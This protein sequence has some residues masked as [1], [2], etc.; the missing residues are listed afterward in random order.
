MDYRS[1]CRLYQAYVCFQVL[2]FHACRLIDNDPALV[3][4]S[5]MESFDTRSDV[6]SVQDCAAL[7]VATVPAVMSHFRAAMRA[8]RPEEL[9]LPQFRTLIRLRWHP[10]V[11]ISDIAEHLG[12]AL[13]TTSQLVDGLVKRGYVTRESAVGDRR[14]MVVTLT[15]AGR[16]MLETVRAAAQARMAEQVAA[17]TPEERQAVASAM[18]ALSRI[19][20][21]DTCHGG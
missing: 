17:L 5:G 1:I 12:L 19:F 4:T 16:A 8:G 14:R 3:Y 13:S 21:Q 11:S 18:A 2:T 9:S 6:L 10:G 15:D 7:L 20:Q